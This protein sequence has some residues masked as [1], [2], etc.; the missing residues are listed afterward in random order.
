MYLSQL[1]I[2]CRQPE[3]QPLL[4]DHYHLHAALMKLFPKAMEGG[5]LLF[6]QEPRRPGPARALCKAAL[7][8][9]A[10]VT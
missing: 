6:R 3:V 4:A 8:R 1:L 5:R 10:A 2:D 9:K 7:R